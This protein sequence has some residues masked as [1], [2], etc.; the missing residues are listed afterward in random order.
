MHP[1]RELRSYPVR[2]DFLPLAA[3]LTFHQAEGLL[4]LALQ[5]WRSGLGD[6]A[7]PRTVPRAIVVDMRQVKHEQDGSSGIAM[8]E[9]SGCV[10]VGDPDLESLEGCIVGESDLHACWSA[11]DTAAQGTYLGAVD[12]QLRCPAFGTGILDMLEEAVLL[13]GFPAVSIHTVS[14]L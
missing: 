13:H 5:Q 4:E 12:S 8:W 11:C 6:V 7:A 3:V 1:G 10:H 14:T 2:D 9:G